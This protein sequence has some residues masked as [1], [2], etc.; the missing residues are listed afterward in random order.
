M[1]I[2]LQHDG[3]IGLIV[4]YGR[5]D[6]HGA[7][8][9]E[10][11]LAAEQRK[12]EAVCIDL[13]EVV[14]ISSAGIGVLVSQLK[15]LPSPELL[16]LVNP[17]EYVR[18]VLRVSGTERLFHIYPNQLAALDALRGRIAGGFRKAHGEEK[19]P[20]GTFSY[21]TGSDAPTTLD[22]VG[23]IADVLHARVTPES[24]VLRKFSETE[25]SIGLGAMGGSGDDCAPFLG[26][27]ITVGGTM[28][29]LPTDGNDTP[30][31][32]IPRADS[33]LVGIRTAFNASLAGAFNEYCLFRAASPRGATMGEIYAQLFSHARAERRDRAGVIA[34]AMCANLKEVYGSGVKIAPIQDF[35]TRD[36]EMIIAPEHIG[37]WFAADTESR[38]AEVTALTVGFGANLE[39]DLSRFSKE[40][41]DAVF[42]I[43][44]AN[45]GAKKQLLH[46]HGV[47]FE[48]LPWAGEDAAFE[49]VVAATVESGTFKD[50]RHLLDTTRMVRALIGI[51]YISDIRRERG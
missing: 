12:A 33:E 3:D 27:M 42:Y 11:Q 16:A 29:W 22:I 1:E 36:G 9:L 8:E 50:M 39:A 38:H 24:L 13:A 37:R 6:A 34:L 45:V 19:T 17:G 32:L 18:E 2:E 23:D 15:R 10:K 43:H 30:D 51:S 31:F 48:E 46:N 20:L 21:K 26:E 25:Y 47:I 14:Y 28:V 49:D 4:L 40:D 41:L 35:A 5:F 44:P 7:G